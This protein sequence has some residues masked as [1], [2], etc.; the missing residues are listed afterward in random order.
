[1][2]SFLNALARSGAAGYELMNER[3]GACLA[4]QLLT[5][6]DSAARKKGLL[7]RDSLA[8][9]AAMIIAPCSAIHTFFMR[10]P[11]DVAFVARDG[12]V[13]KVCASVRPWRLAVAFGAF[14]AIEMPAGACAQSN[15]ARGDRL[16]V[17]L[18]D[19]S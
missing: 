9:A 1:M 13:V 18:R 7:G 14:A 17:R 15:L 12:R 8:P 2:P 10:F 4:D 5:A 19:R 6:F 3:T 16:S 11:I